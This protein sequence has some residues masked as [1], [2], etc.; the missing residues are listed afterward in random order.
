[1]T[2]VSSRLEE[3]VEKVMA[4]MLELQECG[5]VY[6]TVDDETFA[7]LVVEY[8]EGAPMVSAAG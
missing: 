7:V 4:W 3:P 5:L 8:G 2:A 6:A 1:M